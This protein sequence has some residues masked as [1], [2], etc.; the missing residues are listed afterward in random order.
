MPTASTSQIL[1]NNEAIE[2]YTTNIYL[3]RTLA[4]EF[5]VV[6]KHL[7]KCLQELNIWSKELK[8]KM[9]SDGGSIQNIEEIPESVKEIYRTVWEIPQK[10]LID[11]AKNRGCFIDQSQSLNLFMEN[12]TISKLSSMHMYS[13]KSGLKTGIYYLRSKAKARPI[14]FSLEPD[15][16]KSCSA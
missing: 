8:N 2:P 6:N 3:R 16:C 14:Q 7:I 10:S 9:I 11:M 5:V 4:G 15:V 1:G 13:W 12:P